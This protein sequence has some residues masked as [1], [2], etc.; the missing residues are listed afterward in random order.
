[1]KTNIYLHGRIHYRCRRGGTHT[2]THTSASDPRELPS[3]REFNGG[4]ES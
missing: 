3:T 4:S 1:M 2:A